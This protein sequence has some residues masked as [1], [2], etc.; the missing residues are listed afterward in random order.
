[1]RNLTESV[2]PDQHSIWTALRYFWSKDR[3]DAWYNAIFSSGTEVV[4]N[5]MCFAPHVHRYHEKA[6]F[7]LE[8]KEISEDKKRLKVKFFWMP[9]YSYSAK[10][11]IL[12][13][14]SIPEDSDGRIRR[15]GLWNVLTDEKI[16][17][18]DEIC[19]E[20]DDPVRLPLPDWN[21]LQMQWTLHRVAA[22]SGAA[23]SRDDFDEGDDDWDLP[24]G[25]EEDLEDLEEE[26]SE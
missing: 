5:L 1:M 21:L 8:P 20:T 11:D 16:R 6:F 18:G 23:E 26:W 7:A 25:N 10:V 19:L 24:L 9:R 13:T 2:S 4:Y 17:S 14:P 3:V 22:L 12:R 15:V